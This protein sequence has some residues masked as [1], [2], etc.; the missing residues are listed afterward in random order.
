MLV[1]AAVVAP[2]VTLVTIG[3]AALLSASG[4][5]AGS[6]WATRAASLVAILWV[7]DLVLLVMALG[8]NASADS[9]GE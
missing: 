7:V 4:D 8:I 2:I 1:R 6:L 9:D 5:S 3:A